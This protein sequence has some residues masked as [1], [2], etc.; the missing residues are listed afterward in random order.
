MREHCAR[1]VGR[2]GIYALV[3]INKGEKITR[4]HLKFARPEGETP[5]SRIGEIIG[6]YTRYQ[7]PADTQITEKHLEPNNQKVKVI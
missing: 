7:I 2:K 6:R 3:D 1:K 4:V 5:V